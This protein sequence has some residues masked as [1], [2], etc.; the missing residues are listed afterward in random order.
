VFGYTGASKPAMRH[1][2]QRLVAAQALPL[3]LC[4]ATIALAE[5]DHAA[6]VRAAVDSLPCF[7]EDRGDARKDGQ[8]A[9]IAAAVADVSR[10]APRPPR[11][12]AALLLTVGYHE[13]TFSLRIHRGDCKPHECDRGRARSAWQLHKNLFTEPVWE[14][15]HGLEN[16]AVQVRAASDA[17]RRAYYTCSRSGVPWLQATLNG[18][19]GRRC[20]SQWPGLDQR[21]ATFSRLQRTATPR[22]TETSELSP[23]DKSSRLALASQ[24]FQ[25]ARLAQLFAQG[26]E[27]GV[28]R[29]APAQVVQALGEWSVFPQ[30]RELTVQ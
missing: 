20:S 15:L 2:L 24:S 7:V 13:S 1:L 26:G 30:R 3:A 25:D 11:E 21:T 6:W 17:L 12:W 28:G 9:A 18:Y 10:D 19:A 4:F 22:K 16:T 14:Q 29:P 8:L 23:T 27:L 5:S